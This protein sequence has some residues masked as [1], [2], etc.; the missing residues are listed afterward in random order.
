[1][2]VVGAVGGIAGACNSSTAPQGP[3]DP[4]LSGTWTALCGVDVSCVLHLRET[5]QT[6]TGTFG[7]RGASTGME[8][9]DAAT[10][11]F[12][13]PDVT[14]QWNADGALN[15]F[16]GTLEGDTLITGQVT[17]VGGAYPA[18]FIKQQ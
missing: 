8:F 1:M 13:A 15:H 7:T 12:V 6:L 9:D 2:L 17:G 18:R 16:D 11:T 4:P 5:Q 3:G 14:L 10:G